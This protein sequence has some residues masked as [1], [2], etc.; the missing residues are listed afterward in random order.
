MS[1]S[2]AGVAARPHASTDPT[3]PVRRRPHFPCFEGLRALAALAVVF[4]HAG[5]LAGSA[6]SGVLYRPSQMGDI[7]V[8]VFFLLSGFL[9]YRPFVS[10]GLDGAAPMRLRAFWWRR[11]LRILP[12]YWLALTVLWAFGNFHL[13]KMWWRYY[14]LVQTY[15]A[16]T[17]LHGIEQ[18]WSICTEMTFYLLIP[19]WAMLLRR[20]WRGRTTLKVELGGVAVLIAA[21][22]ASRAAFSATTVQWGPGT[23]MRA[24]SF[25][26]LPNQI[27]LFAWGMG[28]AVLHAWASQTGRISTWDR[29]LGR[30]AGLWWA[31]AFGA[32]MVVVYVLGPPSFHVGYKGAYWQ[33]RQILYALVA[34]LLLVPLAFGDQSR[35]GLRTVLR[36]RPVVWVGTVSYALYLWHLDLMKRFVTP[37]P[38]AHGNVPWHGWTGK[39]LGHGNF[40]L[41]LVSGVVLGLIAA[42]VSW[43]ALEKPFLRL[44]RLVA[45]TR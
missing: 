28:L 30:A 20:L 34:I 17:A 22:Y 38:D 27:D 2:S 41:L 24:V 7:G 21:G 36:L 26:W 37:V 15:D 3:V 16:R 10:A 35:G 39:L 23:P 31:A 4:T 25:M 33:E 43:Y 32:F 9:I 13:G 19:L 11:L 40:W 18:A 6:N 8:S 12:A 14:L 5:A 44:K 45:T 29:R 42:A 1:S